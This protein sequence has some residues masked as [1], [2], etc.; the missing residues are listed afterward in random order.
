MIDVIYFG[1]KVSA[2]AVCCLSWC[3]LG[4]DLIVCLQV[5]LVLLW[6]F[7]FDC[8]F[9]V[10]L[11]VDWFGFGCV[12]FDYVCFGVAYSLGYLLLLVM[13]FDDYGLIV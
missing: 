7:R 12:C 9:F 6:G 2:F 5:V 1:F 11:D 13:L 4:F 8:V 3:C 10:L